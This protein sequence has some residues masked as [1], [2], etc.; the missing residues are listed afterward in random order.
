L[1]PVS[2][3]RG[4]LKIQNPLSLPAGRQGRQAGAKVVVFAIKDNF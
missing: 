3:T 4:C 2:S 1:P